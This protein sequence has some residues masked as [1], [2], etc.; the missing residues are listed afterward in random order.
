MNN[1]HILCVFG[2][3]P[4][5]G[6]TGPVILDRHLKRLPSKYE[7]S[8]VA[9]EQSFDGLTFP[10]EW[11]LIPIPMRR[12]WWI[13]YRYQV[14]KLQEVRFWYWRQ[15][16]EKV[17]KVSRP[18]I[19]LTILHDT[20]SVFS[21]YLSKI[22][23]IPLIVI[24]HDQMELVD[25]SDKFADYVK[26]NWKYVLDQA[27]VILPVSFELSISYQINEINKIKLLLPI[28]EGNRNTFVEW[29]EQFKLSPITAY[30]GNIYSAQIPDFRKVA[31]SLSKV[32]GRLLLIVPMSI[33]VKGLLSDC[34]NVDYHEPFKN[35]ADVIEYL[36]QYASSILVNYPLDINTMPWISTSF[37]SKL[38]EFCHLGLPIL[39]IA[40]TTTSL[41]K[42]S[43]EHNWLSYLSNMDDDKLLLTLSN[44]TEKQKWLQM[45]SQSITVAQSEF[46]PEYI[47][48]Q[49][50][51]AISIG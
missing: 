34:P 38:V 32:N 49:F 30:A 26:K 27:T 44:M 7:I 16:C 47:Q 10:D 45:A 41:G 33:E 19:I 3:P 17:L 13:P 24:L 39:I 42:W 22:W 40:P 11:R 5:Q 8:I 9:P 36:S 4:R 28:P 43:L 50:E 51:S 31:K 2:S 20:Y 15:E 1:N 48:A 37:P 25:K 21:A 6:L 46:N 12:W 29:E 14:P 18:T 23:Q 35:N